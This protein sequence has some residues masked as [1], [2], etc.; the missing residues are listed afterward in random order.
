MIVQ[1]KQQPSGGELIPPEKAAD[2]AISS[3]RMQIEHDMGGVKR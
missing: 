2:R 1:P 3:T